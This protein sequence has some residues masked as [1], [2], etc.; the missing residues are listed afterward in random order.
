MRRY[1]LK[2]S[3]LILTV[4]C[5]LPTAGISAWLLHSN[6]ELRR[7]QAEQS[8]L[9]LAR[10]VV[11][12]LESELAAIESALWVLAAAPELQNGDLIGFHT[13]AK[14][15]LVAGSVY[16]YILTDR[17]GHQL[18]NTL[19]PVG[20]AL[21]TT[22]TPS[23]LAQVFEADRAVLTNLFIGPVTRRPAIAMGVPV[24]V[25]G[26][27]RYS[28]NIGLAPE[29]I[30]QLLQRQSLPDGWLIAVLD[31]SGTIVGRSREAERYVGEKGVPAL[32]E[33]LDRQ[34]EQALRIPTKEGIAAFAALKPSQHWGWGVAVGL[35][36]STL[37]AGVRT[38]ILQVLLGTALA[39]GIGLLLALWLARRVLAT[40]RDINDAAKALSAGLPFETPQMQFLEAEAVGLALRQASQAMEEATFRS[41]HDVLTRLPN[42]AMFRDFAERQLG[43]A[44]RNG[45][46]LAFVAIDLDHFKHVNDN[47]GHAAGDEVLVEAARR[48]SSTV[49]SSDLAARLGGDEFIVLLSDTDPD[50]AV[51]TAARIIETLSQPYASTPQSVTGSAGVALYPQDGTTL[52]DL[53]AAADQ[54]L[55]AAKSAGRACMK[56]VNQDL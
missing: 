25:A 44:Q 14:D 22:G 29:R 47:E 3:L 12:D 30:N 38:M 18:L 4:V 46:G 49:R 13:R 19:R 51:Q 1:S 37:Y 6:I 34:T 35:H 9:L 36:E 45:G 26:E 21:P 8:T 16:N 42:R 56:T 7:T 31:R 5:V 20:S 43:L 41:Q 27:V 48:I 33:A 39:L 10:Q 40:V 15:A 23:E 28:L 32:R 17:Q 54:A 2:T 55:Y 53:M 50:T 24:R 52:D 11:A